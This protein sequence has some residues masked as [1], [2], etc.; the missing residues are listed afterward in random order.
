MTLP[1]S[2]YRIQFRDGMTFE[3]AEK[4]IPYLGRL[5]ISHLYA[6]P[7]FTAA[8]GSTHGYD[9]T[10]ANEIDPAIGGRAG[11]NRMSAALRAAG[12]GLLVDIVPNH[13]AA[14]L[15]N[16][17]WRSV[18]EWG[19]ASPFGRH[20]DIDW[21]RK[22]TLPILGKPLD[23]ALKDGELKLAVDT[24]AGVLAIAY[25]EQM[26]PL[27]PGSYADTLMDIDGPGAAKL[28]E[29]AAN[30]QPYQETEFHRSMQALLSSGAEE[31]D[32]ALQRKFSDPA[33]IRKV[34]DA[35][36]WRLLYWKDA[37]RELSYRRFFEVTG[38]VGLRVE[39]PAVFD[40][41]HRLTLELVRS[42]AVDGL[43]LDHIDGLADP[44]GYLDRLRAAVGDDTYIVVEKILAEGETLPT[45]WPISGTTGYEFITALPNVL[46]ETPG[47][48]AMTGTYR[49]IADGEP[50]FADGA[51]AVKAML[52]RKNFA[53]E[54]NT[55]LKLLLSTEAADGE[56]PEDAAIEAALVSLLVACPVYRTYG[57]QD[58]LEA[59]DAA[60]WEKIVATAA[61][62]AGAPDRAALS[63][64]DRVFQ[65]NVTPEAAAAAQEFRRRFQQLTG[66]LTAKSIEDTM[67]YR[68]NRLIGLNEVGGE[69]A[70]DDFG[71][72]RF[73]HAMTERV[74]TQPAG[75]SAT[76]THDTKRGE[77]GRARLYA[78]S[79]APDVWR[80]GVG[81]WRQMNAAHVEKL[82]D[83][84]AP[85][86]RL[87]WMLYQA[88]AGVWPAD[89]GMDAPVPTDLSERFLAY[90]EKAL[91]EAKQR[92][93][94][95]EE[96]GAYEE[97]V[98]AYA[99][100]LLAPDNTVFLQDFRKTLQP[101][102]RAGLFNGLSQT[103]IK[104]A[105]PGIPDIYQGAEQLDV[106]LVDPDNRRMPDYA[107]LATDL[108]AAVSAKDESALARGVVK[109]QLIAKGL[110]LRQAEP[111][112]FAEG[113]Y[114]PIAVTGARAENAVAFLRRHEGKLVIAI[115][116]RLVFK[117]AEDKWPCADYWGDTA[118][119]LPEGGRLT[120]RNVI[121][122]NVFEANGR[123]DL[124]TIL[125]NSPVALLL[126]Q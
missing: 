75:L 125:E 11:F 63:F 50:E 94:W 80:D 25:Y 82:P 34:L 56:A 24:K 9:V 12:I 76:S 32:K 68:Y 3:H 66:P 4:I 78:L 79:E 57:T 35:Q 21:S 118:I 10:D 52:A 88:L 6:S 8:N 49:Q 112:L 104:L 84:A 60:M 81:R 107:S 51:L 48:A 73:H 101:F 7:I 42:G 119:T 77:D 27:T 47:M 87:E 117:L 99:A 71:L 14:S 102:I 22:L 40:D 105:G 53:V 111:R 15:E 54:T 113:D 98:K 72:D 122:G 106:S 67:F 28:A 37:P 55:L 45:A 114:Q 46:V 93:N 97:A 95:G 70:A 44:A 96:N 17:W 92:T 16:P 103:L 36:P 126:S 18:V 23:E 2:T 13:M 58:R 108:S 100:R 30:A 69:P 124:A 20:F 39:D 65:G 38:L 59:S 85:E 91:R 123:L 89:A 90:V 33:S 120:L 116:P 115:A 43:R 26:I 19:A 110:A 83:G 64:I 31:I 109:Q 61:Q 62:S 1:T 41:A 5:G 29:V 74:A 121:D 86:P